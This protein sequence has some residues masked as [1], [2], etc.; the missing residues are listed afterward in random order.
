MS[1]TG[2]LS[3]DKVP[4]KLLIVGAGVIRLELGSVW[5][6]L[7]EEETDGHRQGGSVESG[8]AVPTNRALALTYAELE[9]RYEHAGRQADI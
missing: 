4:G 6:R 7:Y 2:A 1:S 3:L 8:A 5:S 9:R